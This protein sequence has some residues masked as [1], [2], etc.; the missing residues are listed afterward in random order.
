MSQELVLITGGSGHIGFRVTTLALE[1]GYRVRFALRSQARFDVVLEGLKQHHPAIQRSIGPDQLSFVVVPDMA[2]S[3]AY[4]EAAKGV[5]A[6]IHIAGSLVTGVVKPEDYHDVLVAKSVNGTVGVLESAQKANTVKRVIMTSSAVVLAPFATLLRGSG[7]TIYDETFCA[8][9]DDGPYVAEFH[10]YAAGKIAAHNATTAWMKDTNPNFDVVQLE[11][12][13]ILGRS[14]LHTTTQAMMSNM[15]A[16][17][18]GI[19]QGKEWLMPLP[20]AS[21]D[22]GDVARV[23]VQALKPEIPAGAYLINWNDEN[24]NGT[25]WSAV[26]GII[27][28]LF[29]KEVIEGKLKPQDVRP[30]TIPFKATSA[31]L[32]RTFGFNLQGIE[33]QVRSVVGQYLKLLEEEE[34]N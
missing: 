9:N 25:D 7:D 20:G 11:P 29:P 13:F 34:T 33:E 5:F 6:I 19:A 32:E 4:D 28:R 8:P 16:T 23:H 2:A 30:V 14:E 17:I 18:V 31:K 15:N 21:V 27:E 12:S 1:A 3:G 10:A 24:G 22:V 26:P